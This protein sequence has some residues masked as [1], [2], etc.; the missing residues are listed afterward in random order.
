MLATILV[1]A[2]LVAVVCL[3]IRSLLKSRKSGKGCDGDCSCCRGC[4]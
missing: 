4:H 2:V 1:A 3:V